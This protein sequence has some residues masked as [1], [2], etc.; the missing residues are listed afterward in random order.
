MA[1]H[2]TTRTQVSGYRFLLRRME[3]AL[4]RKDARMLSDPL[5]SQNRAL[6]VGLVIAMLGIAGA[7]VLAVLWPQDKVRDASIA[8]GR[9]SGAMFVRVDDVFHPVLN[10]ASARLILEDAAEPAMV[11]EDDLAKYPRGPLLGIPGA[12][13][14]LRVDAATGGAWTVCDSLPG[15]AAGRPESIRTAVIAG[16][17]VLADVRAL[18]DR[19]ALLVRRDEQDFLI[20]DGVRARVDLSDL[21]VVRAYGLEGV[22]PRSVSAGLLNAVPEVPPLAPPVIEGSDEPSAHF[23]GRKVGSVVRVNQA[24]RSQHYVIVR[25]GVQPVG[26]AIA[27]LLRFADSLG[28]G[29]IP[30]VPPDALKRVPPREDLPIDAYPAVA[31]TVIDAPVA[32]LSWTPVDGSAALKVLAGASL[33]VPDGAQ[34]VQRVSAAHADEMLA[35]EVYVAPGGGRFVH[36]VGT[37]GAKLAL[38]SGTPVYVSDTGVRFGIPSAAEAA[39]LGL[40][41]DSAPAPGPILRL[42]TAGPPLGRDE[43]LVAHDGVPGP[44]L[45]DQ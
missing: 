3:H 16:D 44:V 43:A 37:G 39:A 14:T 31:P 30:V 13:Q 36:P 45:P 8:V 22:Q 11:S 40:E 28:A 41:S 10:L 26:E 6:A 12:P 21:A 23:S 4:I 33:P 20:Y 9:D 32:C 17:P 35:D 7:G 19:D 1:G 15:G 29:E 2:V 5:R 38:P 18:G 25:D 42:L 34:L 24:G 27:D